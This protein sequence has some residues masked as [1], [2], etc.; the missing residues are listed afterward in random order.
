M[1]LIQFFL[2]STRKEKR[3]ER[4]K[5][6]GCGWSNNGQ[7]DVEQVKRQERGIRMPQVRVSIVDVCGVLRIVGETHTKNHTTPALH[8]VRCYTPRII[9]L[10]D[11]NMKNM[12][13]PATK[14]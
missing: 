12:K 9:V 13:I 3:D 11:M 14:P 8:A 5:E 6:E 2:C 1:F 4:R 10:A 7:V